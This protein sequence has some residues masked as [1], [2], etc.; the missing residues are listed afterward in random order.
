MKIR[1]TMDID[2]SGAALAP[3]YDGETHNDIELARVIARATERIE[4][5]IV[6]VISTGD[7][8]R[9]TVHDVNGN[10]CIEVSIHEYR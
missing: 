1:V 9:Y 8:C 5:R 4:P 7:V 6:Q 3:E 10:P 2:M